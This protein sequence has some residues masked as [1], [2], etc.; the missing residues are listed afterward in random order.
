MVAARGVWAGAAAAGII[1]NA[2][3]GIL[4]AFNWGA[5]LASVSCSSRWNLASRADCV[6]G[7]GIRMDMVY[8]EVEVDEDDEVGM[9]WTG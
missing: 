8:L 9:V 7:N 4:L 2:V 1:G 5:V 6:P 3:S